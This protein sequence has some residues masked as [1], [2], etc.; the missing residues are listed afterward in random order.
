MCAIVPV[1][2][3]I[4]FCLCV[5]ICLKSFTNFPGKWHQGLYDMLRNPVYHP[6]NRGFDYFYGLP[7]SLSVDQGDE[8]LGTFTLMFPNLTRNLIGTICVTLFT[9]VFLLMISQI[10]L[11]TF[12]IL[13]IISAIFFLYWYIN[14]YYSIFLSSGVLMKNFDT[15]EMPVRLVGLTERFAREG[16]EFI[17]NQT[18]SNNPF[19]LFVS[20][21]HTHT[22][23]APNRK[24]AGHS[25]H[26][27][28]GDCVEEL[29]WGTGLVLKA[30][31]DAGVRDN[32]L[33]YFTSD[34]GGSTFDVGANGQNDGGYNG[35]YRGIS[36]FTSTNNVSTPLEHSR[37]LISIY[38]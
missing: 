19:L 5:E 2:C 4:V 35:I 8:G 22:F 20:W 38:L 34:H 29:D 21:G 26:N 9:L 3:V 32:T 10:R 36:T 14:F 18:R 13:L 37:T 23:L 12:V 33:V 27:R 7:L 30:L 24:F 31:D 1:W 25:R 15:V 28:Y 11:R 17:T 6:N 16:V